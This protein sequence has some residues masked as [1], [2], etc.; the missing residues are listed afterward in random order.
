MRSIQAARYSP[1]NC[2]FQGDGSGPEDLLRP[3]MTRLK[4]VLDTNARPPL[5]EAERL[6]MLVPGQ[7]W[8]LARNQARACQAVRRH[9]Q[10][11]WRSHGS[12]VRV[13]RP[14][15]HDELGSGA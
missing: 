6:A 2:S 8:H 13:Q 12:V 5:T 3:V 4:Y 1:G 9:R 10:P 7:G 15:T 14:K 11:Y